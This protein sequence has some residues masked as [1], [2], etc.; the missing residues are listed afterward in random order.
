MVHTTIKAECLTA[1][2]EN[3]DL[4][5]KTLLTLLIKPLV[6]LTKV[7]RVSMLLALEVLVQ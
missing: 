7:V 2:L 3:I 4:I 1:L 6:R 5:G